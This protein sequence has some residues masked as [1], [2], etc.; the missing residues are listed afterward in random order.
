MQTTLKSGGLM[1]VQGY[2]PKQLEYGTG[3]PK[4][5]ENLYTRVMLETAFA[6]FK[7]VRIEQ[8]DLEMQEGTAHAG[9]SAVINFTA[10]K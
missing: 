6:D 4:L 5:R 10:R 7:D 8:E 1:I 2:R 9:M 3:G